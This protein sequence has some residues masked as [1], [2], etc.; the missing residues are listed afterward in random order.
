MNDKNNSKSKS[1]KSGKGSD[2]KNDNIDHGHPGFSSKN[3]PQDVAED[4]RELGGEHS[5][6]NDGDSTNSQDERRGRKSEEEGNKDERGGKR[7]RDDQ[8]R[9]TDED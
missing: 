2:T 8:G 9:F 5:H 1:S 7:S 4:A 3:Y 6:M